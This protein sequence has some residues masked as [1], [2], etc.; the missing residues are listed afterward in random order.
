MPG[1][2]TK[3]TCTSGRVRMPRITRRVVCGLS[4]TI[5]TLAPTYKFNSVDLPTLG[6]PTMAQ[7]PAR[8]AGGADSFVE[9][10]SFG[11]LRCGIM[12]QEIEAGPTAQAASDQIHPPFDFLIQR[13]ERHQ[14]RGGISA[15]FELDRVLGNRF[16][17]EG[18]A[19][20]QTD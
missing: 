11:C 8:C 9:R 20:R 17:S 3:I 14:P 18:D 4:E 1:V 7:K 15:R 5:V 10:F 13:V 19:Q 16:G 6:R 12:A 2:S